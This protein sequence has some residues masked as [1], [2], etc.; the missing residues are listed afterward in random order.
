[1]RRFLVIFLVVGIG[2]CVAG[3]TNRP[4]AGTLDLLFPSKVR[5][6]SDPG[7]RPSGVDPFEPSGDRDGMPRIGEPIRPSE[8]EVPFRREGAPQGRRGTESTLPDP[9]PVPNNGQ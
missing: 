7:A 1:M 9:L 4:I 2:I 3:C 8:S 5:Y 6:K